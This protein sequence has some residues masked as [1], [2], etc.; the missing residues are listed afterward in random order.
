MGKSSEVTLTD[1]FWRLIEKK[2]S[3]VALITTLE[4]EIE[5]EEANL[6]L[7]N[8]Q[9]S[10]IYRLSKETNQKINLAGREII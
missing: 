8:K 3:S 5:R 6:K 1:V 9:L 2:A 4:Q 10:R 7:I